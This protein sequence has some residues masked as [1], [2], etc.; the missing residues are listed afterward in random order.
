MFSHSR[1]LVPTDFSF[2]S[3]YAMKYAVAMARRYKASIHVVHAVDTGPLLPWACPSYWFLP[4]G[5]HDIEACMRERAAYRLKHVTDALCHAGIATESSVLCGQPAAAI[6][7]AVRTTESDLV[8][9]GTHGRVGLEHALFGSVAEDVARRSP[10]PVLTIRHPEHEFLEF[11]GGHLHLDR[12]LF[13]TDFSAFSLSALPYAASL[14]REFG[15]TLVLMHVTE[16]ISYAGEFLPD[17][18]IIIPEEDELDRRERLAQLAS[19]CGC[20]PVEIVEEKGAPYPAIVA[21]LDGLAIDLLVLPTHG[22]S[23]VARLFLGG[24]A[25]RVLRHASCPVLTVRPEM[26][27]VRHSAKESARASDV[28]ATEHSPSLTPVGV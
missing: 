2:Q 16:R 11:H 19:Q 28:E 25:S 24:V 27:P 22:H 20:I 14:C 6:V 15:S 5:L 1:L 23:G 21:A 17:A 10:A 4:D 8:V 18:A 3:F 9:V 26:I 7:D 12:I 13:P